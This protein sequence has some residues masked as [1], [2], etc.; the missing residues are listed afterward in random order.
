MNKG[1]EAALMAIGTAQLMK[2]SLKRCKEGVWDGAA[3]LETGG[4]PSSHS[5]GVTALATYIA[6]SK[7]VRTIDFALA[8]IFGLII[9]YDAMGIRR[10]AGETAVEVN[11]LKEE[12]EKLARKHRGGY[13]QKRE[14]EL[15]EV[16]GHLPGEV[17]VGCLL[18]IGVGSLSY[19]LT[20]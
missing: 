2:V 20:E 19:L 17:A 5:A 12:V 18:G 11:D 8:S 4:M 3:L 7:G 10:H 16:L 9:M 6:L 1:I 15:K 13:H 14:K